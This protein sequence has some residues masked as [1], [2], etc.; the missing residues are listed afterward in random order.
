MLPNID[1]EHAR[2]HSAYSP[3]YPS[4][5]STPTSITFLGLNHDVY[6][7]QS[8]EK[9]IG[10]HLNLRANSERSVFRESWSCFMLA[11]RRSFCSKNAWP[12]LTLDF[13]SSTTPRLTVSSAAICAMSWVFASCSSHA[14]QISLPLLFQIHLCGLPM[15]VCCPRALPDS[16]LDYSVPDACQTVHSDSCDTT[17]IFK[18]LVMDHCCFSNA[19]SMQHAG[20]IPEQVRQ[21]Y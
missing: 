20:Q 1:H 19:E 10:T 5:H 16:G 2:F 14:E 18:I 11:S 12:D 7:G 4:L 21:L 8:Q 3:P 17:R 13:S 9:G 6:G 15:L